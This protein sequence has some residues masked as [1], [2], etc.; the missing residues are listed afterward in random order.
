MRLLTPTGLRLSPSEARRDLAV[1]GVVLVADATLKEVTSFLDDWTVPYSHPHESSPGVTVIEPG[2]P[3]GD[4]RNGFT[5]GFL[6]LHT[7]RAQSLAPPTIL[8]C[9]YLRT[10]STGGESLLL[11]GKDLVRAAGERSQLGESAYVV[12][13]SRGRPWLPVIELAKDGHRCRI[14]YR[15]DQVARPHAATRSARPLLTTISGELWAPSV[16][17]FE[18]GQGYLIHNQRF[19]HGRAAFSGRRTALRILA[20]VARSSE[21][22][23]INRGF[24]L[25]DE[26]GG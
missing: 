18:P 3:E 20:T 7:D 13:R 22:A 26:H 4:N 10:S 14:R 15:N 21:Y 11:D 1:N 8:G 25:R 6:S 19:L 2:R 24:G 16:R 9:L 23:H 5:C 17:L 12:L